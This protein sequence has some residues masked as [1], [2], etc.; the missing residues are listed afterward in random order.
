MADSPHALQPADGDLIRLAGGGDRNAF[1]QLY[2][3]FARPI[4]GLALRRLGSPDRA[5]D[6]TQETFT[7]IWRAAVTYRPER[8]PVADQARL[9]GPALAV[10]DRDA[11]RHSDRAD[12]EAD[13]RR[14]RPACRVA[15]ARR[16]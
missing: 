2:R 12:Q 1:D 7:S 15:R 14:T 13:A 16:P 6:A 10:R 11:A 3:R 8:G 9:L 4:F 5:E